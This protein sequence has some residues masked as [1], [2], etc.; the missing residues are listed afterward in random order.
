[1]SLSTATRTLESFNPAT[2]ARLGR[3]AGRW[4]AREAGAAE[5]DD[6][7]DHDDHDDRDPRERQP[8]PVPASGARVASSWHAHIV[9]L[10][11][12]LVPCGRLLSRTHG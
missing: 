12:A 11:G 4:R 10:G 8:E 5:R 2:G 9:A 3:V 6:Q 1:M 7:H